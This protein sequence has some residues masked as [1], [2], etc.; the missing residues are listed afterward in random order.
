MLKYGF[1]KYK[2]QEMRDKAVHS[3]VLTLGFVPDQFVKTKMLEKLDNSIFS[4][5]DLFFHEVDPKIFT[6]LSNDMSFNCIDLNNIDLDDGNF[7]EEDTKTVN[8]A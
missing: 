3:Y 8:H 4:N 6:I 1:G 7:D 5:G 2:S